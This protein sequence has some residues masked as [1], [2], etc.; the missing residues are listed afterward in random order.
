MKNKMLEIVLGKQYIEFNMP[1][2]TPLFNQY[3][4]FFMITTDEK[5]LLA[6]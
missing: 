5:D 2:L 6:F 1:I 4:S 3:G